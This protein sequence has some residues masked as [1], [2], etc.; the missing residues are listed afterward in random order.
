MNNI[1]WDN[2]DNFIL[3]S[4]YPLQLLILLFL[5]KELFKDEDMVLV[6]RFFLKYHYKIFID[7]NIK[8]VLILLDTYNLSINL[9]NDF[10]KNISTQLLLLKDLKKFKIAYDR[11]YFWGKN[12]NEQIEYLDSLHTKFLGINDC[13]I[14]SL[15]FHNKLKIL[16][17][18][19]DNVNVIEILNRLKLTYKMFGKKFFDTYNINLM[20]YEDFDDISL[21]GKIKFIEYIFIKVNNTLIDIIEKFKLYNC[22][23][24]YIKNIINPKYINIE[25]DVFTSEIDDIDF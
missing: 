25:S 19:R 20:S 4:K 14:G 10:Y 9:I 15:Y 16:S 17:K 6:I 24:N 8:N 7:N 5:K 18:D 13:S 21:M 23:I 3:E 22:M 12:I 2:I 11:K 1:I